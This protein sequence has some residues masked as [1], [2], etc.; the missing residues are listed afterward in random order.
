[1]IAFG[2]PQFL[3]LLLLVPLFLLVAPLME[4]RRRRSLAVFAGDLARRLS[5]EGRGPTPRRV[6][7]AVA[8]GFLV[9][10][11]ADPRYGHKVEE[12]TQRGVDVLFVLDVSRSMLA[13]DVQPSRLAKARA[14]I[15]FLADRLEGERLGLVVFAGVPDVLCPLTLDRGAFGLFL[16]LAD[17]ELIPVPGTDLGA[18]LR[19][20]T[21]ALGEEGLEYKVV[22]LITDGEDHEGRGL[23]TAKDAAEKG[24]RIH[25]VNVGAGG[26]PLPGERGFRKDKDGNTIFSKPDPDG[27]AAIAAATGGGFYQASSPRLELGALAAEIASMEDRD[28]HGE[29]VRNKETRYQVPL[30]LALVALW[31]EFFLLPQR[32]RKGRHLA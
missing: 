13:G 6:A 32:R 16:D 27:L 31:F 25:T 9:L 30:F 15:R 1:V 7:R 5:S 18:A 17:T 21:E 24:I 23:A 26:A 14:E 3:P 10:A 2:A 4:R 28:L 12:L 11:L 8:L 29:E 19:V 22:V 20:A